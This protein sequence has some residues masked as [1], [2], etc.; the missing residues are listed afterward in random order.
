MYLTTITNTVSDFIHYMYKTTVEYK[1]LGK[2]LG[3]KLD[4]GELIGLNS[5]ETSIKY[6][7][8]HPITGIR[9]F[10]RGYYWSTLYENM[11]LYS[12]ELYIIDNEYAICVDDK[13]RPIYHL[14]YGWTRPGF[15]WTKD[16]YENVIETRAEDTWII[17]IDDYYYYEFV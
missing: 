13:Q 6:P 15:Y 9:L 1:N 3:K 17:D 8:V 5:I 16:K 12:N 7:K 10:E 11:Y 2:N 14:L 4:R